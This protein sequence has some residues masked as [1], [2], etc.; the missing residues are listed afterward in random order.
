MDI[1]ILFDDTNADHASTATKA[2]AF[3]LT[4]D[5]FGVNVTTGP[6]GRL[7]IGTAF[8]A[9]L[10]PS[11]VTL[12]GSSGPYAILSGTIKAT[13]EGSKVHPAKSVVVSPMLA[14]GKSFAVNKS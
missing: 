11:P 13:L 5:S 14:M 12:T 8:G 9:V 10:E 3:N 1:L 4:L 2:E 7:T 6:R